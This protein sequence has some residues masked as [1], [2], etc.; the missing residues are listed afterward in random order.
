MY[1]E[2]LRC[3]REH[4]KPWNCADSCICRDAV[5]RGYGS[6]SDELAKLAADAIE[7][8]SRQ[9]ARWEEVVKTALDFIP[10]WVSVSD[11]LP[12]DDVDV[13]C[14][15][16]NDAGEVYATVGCYRSI[17]K[18]W[19]LDAEWASSRHVTHWMPLPEMSAV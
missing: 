12:E 3:L 8:L 11:H 1:K 19:D 7:E 17:F 16:R 14:M 10:C 4:S 5:K 18:S 9:N 15:L 13:L 2:L 6:C